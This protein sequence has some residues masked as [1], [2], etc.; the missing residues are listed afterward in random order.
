MGELITTK[1]LATH[2]H[3]HTH[4]IHIICIPK[5]T[6]QLNQPILKSHC[7]T[8]KSSLD[9]IDASHTISYELF[10]GY[11]AN[12]IYCHQIGNNYIRKVN[13]KEKQ[14]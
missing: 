9:I 8:L 14:L 1:T 6:N 2:I 13:L 5:V 4:L 7:F 12:T 11:S 10:D 3:T